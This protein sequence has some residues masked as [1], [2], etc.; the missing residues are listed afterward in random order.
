MTSDTGSTRLAGV[1]LLTVAIFILPALAFAQDA[2]KTTAGDIKEW[3]TSLSNWGR[4]GEDDQL[5]TLNLITAE[6]RKAAAALVSDGVSISLAHPMITETTP[7]NP[8]PLKHT[9]VATG[10]ADNPSSYSMDRYDILYHGLAHTHLDSLCHIF[11]EGKMYNGFDRAKVTDEGCG[12][13]GIANFQQ[14]VFTRGVL[15]DMAWFKG[16]DYLEPATAIYPEDLEAWEKK[17]GIE[18]EPGDAVLVRTGRWAR[19][20]EKG[21][22]SMAL[23]SAGLHASVAK[24]L[25]ARD[26]AILG[27]DMASDV[28]PSGV[29]GFAGLPIHQLTIVAMGLPLIDNGDY[30]ELAT[31]AKARGRWTFLL[32][33]APLR[34][35]G[36]TG[37]PINPIATF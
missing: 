3:M 31:E 26:V 28:M 25:K 29:E 32:A 15:I 18:V 4:W 21:P 2:P 35:E 19:R 23:G 22:W 17:T 30:E 27:S 37:S 6:K 11:W 12:K 33:L 5:G 10:A 8:N 9:M 20:A 24:W 1:A 14:G 36:G 7:D 13:L 34:V 16:V